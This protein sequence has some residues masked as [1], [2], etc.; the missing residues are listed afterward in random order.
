MSFTDGSFR[1]CKENLCSA[2][3]NRHDPEKRHMIH[4]I[5]EIQ[6]DPYLFNSNFSEYCYDPDKFDGTLE[7]YPTRL[8]LGMDLSCNLKCPSCRNK[9]ISEYNK[10]ERL[11]TLYANLRSITPGIQDLELDG[12]GDV[13]ASNWYQKF[14][15]HFPVEDFPNLQTI[16]LRSNGLLWNEKNWYRIHPYFRSKQISACIT[17]DAISPK[18]MKK[19]AVAVFRH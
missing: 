13:F 15:K 10:N 4:T 3:A 8:Y 18:P 6:S 9:L 14:L 7:S 19:C 1:Y 2:A 12:A 5:D 16:T 11:D 17:V